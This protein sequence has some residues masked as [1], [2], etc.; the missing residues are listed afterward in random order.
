MQRDRALGELL[1]M[2][3]DTE[4]VIPD[5][6]MDYY[7]ST[8][9]FQTDD[10]RIKRLLSLSVQK[11]VSDLATDALQFTKISQTSRGRTSKKMVLNAQDLSRALAEYGINATKPEY[12]I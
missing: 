4:P 1:E 11:F 8:A 5:E 9:G 10:P 3:T 12:Y 2:H 7:L 6:L